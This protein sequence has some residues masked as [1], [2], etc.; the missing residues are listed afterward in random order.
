MSILIK[1]MDIPK[2]CYD[3][4]H[5]C[6]SNLKQSEKCILTDS[7]IETKDTR[8]KRGEDCPII[9]VPTP[10]GRLIDADA[11]KELWEG[12]TFEGSIDVLLD[13]RP[14]VI[15]AEVEE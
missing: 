14:T 2:C 6:W 10:H 9:E 3:C 4:E 8:V 1:G 12:C 13:V 11:M 5:L 7:L 15:E